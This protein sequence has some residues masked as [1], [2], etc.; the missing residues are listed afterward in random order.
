MTTIAPVGRRA[1]LKV[2]TLAGGGLL[3]AVYGPR[4]GVAARGDRPAADP[5]ADT[6]LN[7]FIRFHDDGT[8]TILSKNPEIGQGVKTALP[9]IIAEE[10]DVPWAK[11][12]IEQAPLDPA[13][14]GPQFAGGS[15]ATPLNWD[16]LRRTGAAARAMLVGAA[17]K[18]WN[19]AA[20]TCTTADAVVTHAPSGRTATYASLLAVAATITP[21]ALDQVPLK[22]PAAYRLV[23]KPHKDVDIHKIVT[24]QPL[25]GIDVVV[26]GMHHAV[27]EKCPVFGGKLVSANVDEV[28]KLPGVTHAFVVKGGPALDGLLDG[29]AIVADSWWHAQSA[30]G[31]LKVQWDGGATAATSTAGMDAKARELARAPLDKVTRNEGDVAAA[32][33]AAPM[34]VEA[35]YSYPFI[36]HA[37]LEP[38]NTTAEWKDGKLEIWSPTQMPQPGRDLVA[39]TLGIPPADITIHV[40]RSGGGF[41]RRLKNDYM[42]EAAQIAKTAGVP[43]KLLWTREDD[44]AHDHYRQA[45][46]HF[47]R[48]AVDAQGQV[49]AWQDRM[50][51]DEIGEADFPSRFVPNLRLEVSTP[52]HGVPTGALRAPGSNGQAFVVQSFVDELAFAARRDPLQFR[53]DMLRRQVT[54][55]GPR[56]RFSAERMAKVLEVVRD[57]SGWGKTLPKGRGMGVAFHF[58]HRGYFAEVVE[59]GVGARGGLVIHQVWVVGDIGRQVINPINAE[60]QAIGGALEGISHALA[61]ELTIDKG[62]AVEANFDEYALLRMPNAPPVD[63][64]F[65]LTD[66]SP[67]GLGEPALP[68]VI[69]ALCNAI[70]AATGKRI[71]KLPIGNQLSA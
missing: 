53:L 10:L 27:Y 18:Q 30:R 52:F 56:D 14:F 17:A 8:V 63:V 49:V 60:H 65:H 22:D 1:F 31:K 5:L 23:G 61:Q 2:A 7:A 50:V 69:P 55:P 15:T 66:N 70:F 37:P 59:A 36:V 3:V 68:P 12:T 39:K 67:T 25:Y 48:G 20:A 16:L 71:R 11:V 9:L 57:R 46:W 21:P 6:Q 43:V 47:F 42:V 35:Q 4:L 29:V 62:R 34:V 58:S 54:P 45:G 40:T 32:L 24:G 38:Q 41:G 64:F 33:A 28:R 51:Y 13:V 19:V 26:P 44:F